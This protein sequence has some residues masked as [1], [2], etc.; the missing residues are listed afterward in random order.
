ML[1][2]NSAGDMVGYYTQGSSE[3][4]TGFIF[5]G[6]NFTFF[7]Y[8]GADSTEAFGIN[9]SGLICGTAYGAP[10]AAAVGFLYD[11]ANFT[12]IRIPNESYTIVNGIINPN[13]LG[14]K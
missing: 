4:A 9:D 10:S 2:I 8:P 12:T 13:A 1:G 5:S 6:G 14:Y 11:L 7:S 3:P